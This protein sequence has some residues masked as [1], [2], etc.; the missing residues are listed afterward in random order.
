MLSTFAV[1]VL[2]YGDNA[3]LLKRCLSSIARTHC[4]HVARVSLGCNAISNEADEIARHWMGNLAKRSHALWFAEE[5][6]DNVWKYPLMRRMLHFEDDTPTPEYVVWFDDD[7]YITAVDGGWW[8]KL[9]QICEPHVL[10]GSIYTIK[11][12]RPG[13]VDAMQYQPWFSGREIR[14]GYK[15]RFCTGGFWAARLADLKE[16]GYPWL[17]LKHNGGDSML[18]EAYRQKGWALRNFREGVAINADREGRESKAKRRGDTTTWPW[19]GWKPGTVPDIG[20]Q[21]FNTTVARFQPGS[22][23]HGTWITWRTV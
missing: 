21:E 13:Q 1:N 11:G 8:G 19:E 12:F 9:A 17:E 15:P 14:P 4:K 5:H 6:G 16:L 10:V 20:H 22:D 3:L 18:G 23:G 2:T 7:S